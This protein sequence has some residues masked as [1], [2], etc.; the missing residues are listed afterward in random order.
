MSVDDELGYLSGFMR[1][2]V[3]SCDRILEQPGDE[4]TARVIT[5]VR[6][7]V[8]HIQGTVGREINARKERQR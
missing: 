5:A 1:G 2:A 8:T 4:T 3:Q 6:T 7:R